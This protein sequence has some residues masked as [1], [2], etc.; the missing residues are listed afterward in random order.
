MWLRASYTNHHPG[1]IASFFLETVST[2]GGYPARVRT[3]CG[4]ENVTIAAVQSFVTG[5]TSGHVYGTSPGNQRIEAWW[6]FFRRYRTQWWIELFEGLTEYGA[7]HPG[8]IIETECLRFCFMALIQKDL[9]E[10]RRQ[11]N[12]HR[13]R[14]SAGSRCPAG[15]PDELYYLPE[16]PAVDCTLSGGNPLPNEVLAQLAEPRFCEDID[17]QNYFKYLC[18]FHNW[19]LPVDV[20]SASELYF[21]LLQ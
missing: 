17:R 5:S 19:C 4:T 20:D 10:V 14:P 16:L 8:C 9:D 11:W 7:F 6:S 18:N 2:V 15:I 21:N 12:T 3:D 13:I 1:L